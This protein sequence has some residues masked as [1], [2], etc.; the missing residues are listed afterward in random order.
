MG[1]PYELRQLTDAEMDK[2]RDSRVTRFEAQEA[3]E[4]HEAL[5][6]VLI[7]LEARLRLVETEVE[8]ASRA[9]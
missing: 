6:K 3:V 8:R 7:A 1:F 4:A 9:S 2:L 5:I